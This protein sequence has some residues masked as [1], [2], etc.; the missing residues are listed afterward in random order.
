MSRVDCISWYVAQNG[1]RSDDD[2][3][4]KDEEFEEELTEAG[5]SFHKEVFVTKKIR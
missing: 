3:D 1:E 4:A 2:T 5:K